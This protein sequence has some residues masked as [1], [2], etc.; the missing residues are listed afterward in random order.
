MTL[1]D[2]LTDIYTRTG[3]LTP[4]VLVD[5]ARSEDHPLHAHI[6]NVPPEQAAELHYEDRARKLIARVKVVMTERGTETPR[7]VRIWHAIPS[8]ENAYSFAPITVL[9]NEPNKLQAALTEASR[10]VSQAQESVEDLYLIASMGTD[11]DKTKRARTAKRSL[12]RAHT[13][14]TPA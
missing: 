9:I 11:P 1:N 6:F 5:E 14:L 2:I 4:R 7:R 8:A 3:E 13:A 10:R 12:Q